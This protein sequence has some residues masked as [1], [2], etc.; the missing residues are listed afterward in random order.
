MAL[1]IRLEV[2]T[3]ETCSNIVIKDITGVYDALNNPG[4]WGEINLTSMIPNESL[5]VFIT[6]YHFIS[7]VQY[8]TTIQIPE[9]D[10][11][12]SY[13]ISQ[14]VRGFKMSI[15]ADVVSTAVANQLTLE[16]GVDLPEE[17]NISQETLEDNIYQVVV[18]VVH[19]DT[20][21]VSEPTVF[22]STCN[23]RRDVELL[24]TSI[25]T[26]CH[27]CDDSDF[28]KALLAKSILEGLENS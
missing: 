9:S 14:S 2:E 22:K 1:D 18:R 8:T 26:S 17:Y 24:L 13:P 23:M 6:V 15:P 20:I 21:V 16:Q 28:D 19:E 3:T 12:T 25:D 4:G 11:Y 5:S 10:Y 7:D 27:D